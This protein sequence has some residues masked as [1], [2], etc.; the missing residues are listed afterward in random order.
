[1]RPVTLELTAFGSFAAATTVD[2]D[3]FGTGIYLITGDT[4]AGK[5]TLFDGILFALYGQVSG[6]HRQPE[7][8]HSDFVSRGVDTRVRLVFEHGGGRQEV[9]RTL[10]FK[11]KRGTQEYDDKPDKKALLHEAGKSPVEGSE[12]VTRRIEEMLG[13]NCVQFQQ[14]VMLAQ[15]EFR[16]FL[17]AGSD[18]R[19][20]ILGKLF[21]NLPY[22][23]FEKRLKRCEERMQEERREYRAEIERTMNGRFM[24]PEGLDEAGEACFAPDYPGLE[25]SLSE[26]VEADEAEL[27]RLNEACLRTREQQ[28]RMAQERAVAQRQNQS[29]D[30]LRTKQARVAGL[31]Q[32]DGEIRALEGAVDA[33]DRALHKVSP[34]IARLAE[35]EKEQRNAQRRMDQLKRDVLSQQKQLESS[36]RA[37]EQAEGTQPKIDQ[38]AAQITGLTRILPEYDA[39]AMLEA[40]LKSQ[41]ALEKSSREELETVKTRLQKGKTRLQDIAQERIPL[42]EAGV[43]KEKW[44]QEGKQARQAYDRI[45]GKKAG[46]LVE[47]ENVLSSENN[48]ALQIQACRKAQAEAEKLG[49]RHRELYQRFLGSQAQPLRAELA[50]TLLTEEQTLCPVCGQQVHRGHVLPAAQE[51]APTREQVEQARERMEAAQK[52]QNESLRQLEGARSALE[53]LRGKFVQNSAECL[54]NPGVT[55]EELRSGEL[56]K[57]EALRLDA[58]V[59]EF[60][61]QYQS[62]DRQVKQD[63]A[64][65]KEAEE[66]TARIQGD[67]ALQ[68]Q[69]EEVFRNAGNECAKLSAQL[70]EKQQHLQ[71]ASA[72][73]ARET[74]K[75]WE[76][77]RRNL[78]DALTAAREQMKK[79]SNSLSRTEGNLATSQELVRRQDEELALVRRELEQAVEDAGFDSLKSAQ[80]A[81][82]PVG[83][84]NGEAWLKGRR[85]EINAFHQDL[86]AARQ[87]V[88]DLQKSTEGFVY[89]DLPAMDLALRGIQEQLGVREKEAKEVDR[90]AVNHREVRD[91][92]KRV[93]AL[94]RRDED[95]YREIQLLSRLANGTSNEEGGKLTFDRYV[96]GA[97]FRDILRAANFRLSVLSGGKYE[98]LHRTGGNAASRAAGLDIDVLDN[99]TGESRRAGSLS[100][101][102]SF[103][104][105]MALALGLWDVATARAG[106]LQMDVMYIDEGFGSLDDSVLDRAISVLDALAGGNRQI[107]IIS[108]VHK[109]EESIPRK[110]VVEGTETGSRI[111]PV[112]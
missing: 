83:S 10:H 82:V 43:L 47:R 87:S 40:E 81:L 74:L 65:Q 95:A 69:K 60:R 39:C 106:G 32:R 75:G 90:R 38:L 50:Q 103:Q 49:E 19:N 62:A 5:T 91:L 79:D 89:A 80:E 25:E 52:A 55:W 108:H 15:G 18:E 86:T 23:R 70:K 9:V 37:C 85:Q 22:V 99:V 102:E 35:K 61:A 29:L 111:R 8:M 98:L 110:L 63:S 57:E 17:D 31:A 53:V 56:L 21:D 88:E 96:M 59:K 30:D 58:K 4:G 42:R 92:V 104:V 78:S 48:L 3:A 28:T 100:G 2:F 112:L 64:L 51:E 12:N 24:M 36:R 45:S 107:G 44:T 76:K 68:Q 46:L 71:Y 16:K 101:G 33:V 27:A 73:A 93:R 13:L 6:Q 11:K 77:E 34:V 54:G 109:L 7:M 94:L 67:E 20:R 14:I 41:Q 72:D 105:S 66:L 84:A 1:M 26:L 97:A